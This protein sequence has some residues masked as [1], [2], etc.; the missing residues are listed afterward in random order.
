MPN[1]DEQSWVGPQLLGNATCP[2]CGLPQPLTKLRDQLE[3]YA[4]TNEAPLLTCDRCGQQYR[5]VRIEKMTAV[6]TRPGSQ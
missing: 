2:C 4:S 1:Q 5:V 6:W 3:I